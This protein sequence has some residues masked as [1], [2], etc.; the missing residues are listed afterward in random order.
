L[1]A[2]FVPLIKQEIQIPLCN[3][4][5]SDADIRKLGGRKGLKW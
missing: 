2:S 5:F 3:A 4:G 1:L